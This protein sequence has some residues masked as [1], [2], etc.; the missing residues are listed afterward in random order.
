M[1]GGHTGFA[2]PMSNSA[3]RLG[4]PTPSRVDGAG[5]RHPTRVHPRVAR[6][7]IAT[8][9][10][11]FH[12]RRG[13]AWGRCRTNGRCNL[14]RLGWVSSGQ[15][16]FARDCDRDSRCPP[17]LPTPHPK[18][19]LSSCRCRSA[20]RRRVAA[21]VGFMALAGVAAETGVVLLICLDNATREV[22]ARSAS[23]GRQED[24]LGLALTE[25]SYGRMMNG[26]ILGDVPSA[27]AIG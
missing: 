24:R 26:K 27:L 3:N 4:V 8:D 5:R 14:T 1:T 12:A 16:S 13:R 19:S 11:A 21:A 9:D 7:H 25:P 2:R 6:S 18:S 15:V 20:G 10:H 23:D 22:R 17:Q